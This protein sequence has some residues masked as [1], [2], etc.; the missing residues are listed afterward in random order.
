MLSFKMAS[1][2]I[3]I[4]SACSSDPQHLEEYKK[5]V[6]SWSQ[7]NLGWEVQVI[8]PIVWESLIR[9]NP[10][11]AKIVQHLPN[12]LQRM[13]LA[14]YLFL[15]TFGGLC[16]DINVQC[17]RSIEFVTSYACVLFDHTFKENEYIQLHVSRENKTMLIT[18][19]MYSIPRHPFWTSVMRAIQQENVLYTP[20]ASL[21][22]RIIQCG[23]GLIVSKTKEMNPSNITVFDDKLVAPCSWVEMPCQ[24]CKT[25]TDCAHNFPNSFAVH[26][27]LYEHGSLWMPFSNSAH[28]FNVFSTRILK[29]KKLMIFASL[30]ILLGLTWI[31]K[32]SAWSLAKRGLG[33]TGKGIISLF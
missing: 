6:N 7:H 16:V 15:Y 22:L 9:Q 21:E 23:G 2:Y 30:I 26:Q 31:F 18:S 4:F 1:R 28:W 33:A 20:H 5:N 27:P 32:K 10:L 29:N 14:K 13:N 8:F 24:K 11:T 12:T 17:L 25:C 19:I 3:H